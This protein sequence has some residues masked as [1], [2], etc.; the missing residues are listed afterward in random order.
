MLA[1]HGDHVGGEIVGIEHFQ[2][3]RHL[4]AAGELRPGEQRVEESPSGIGVDLD[5]PRPLAVEMEVVAHKGAERAAVLARDFRRPGEHC[6]AIGRHRRHRLDR[7][8]DRRHLADHLRRQEDGHVGEEMRPRLDRR[9][10]EFRIAGLAHQRLAQC[11]AV[12]RHAE[13][14]LVQPLGDRARCGLRSASKR[15]IHGLALSFASA[16]RF[17]GP[18]P[19]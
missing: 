13:A 18:A 5:E 17:D 8:D 19:R 11:R 14:A 6:L 1:E 2:P 16:D 15:L 7:G 10:A 12:E 4:A 3:R 9:G